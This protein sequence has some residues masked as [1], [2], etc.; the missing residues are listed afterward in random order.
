MSE[1]FGWLPVPACPSGE[2]GGA[3]RLRLADRQV[4]WQGRLDE[5]L[6]PDHIA[7]SVLMFVRRLDL[8]PLRAMIRSRGSRPGGPAT[9]P[10][11]LVALWLLAIIDGVGSAR[12]LARLC[13]EHIA[14]RWLCGGVGMNQ[15]TL[16][17]FRVDH[18][19]WLDGVFT[20]SVAALL[21]GGVISLAEVAQDGLRVRAAAGAGSL[22]RGE[23]LQEHLAAA[24]QQVE[25]LK[26]AA[27]PAAAGERGSRAARERAA[28]ERQQRLEAA[29][30]A[31]P[32]AQERLRRN[33][34]AKKKKNGK[35]AAPKQAR[36]STTD[37]EAHV[38]KMPDGGFRPA[39]NFQ[40]SAET[41]NGFI[42]G[43]DASDSGA[44]QPSLEPMVEQ[45]IE[46]TGETPEKWLVDGG[47]VKGQSITALAREHDILTYAPPMAGKG[48]RDPA[49]PAK[50]DTPE[51]AEWRARMAS[52]AAKQIYRRRAATIECVN[53]QARQRGLYRITVRSRRKARIIALWYAMAHNLI[54]GLRVARRA[55]A[56]A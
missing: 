4:V 32:E 18:E 44:D 49:E 5:L 36:V 33:G 11:I 22:R 23:S 50:G 14:Y 31:L 20:T 43:V 38:M 7:R 16:S 8:A 24:R 41:T 17:D 27:Q 26:A 48:S 12:M 25:A 6:D 19:V 2:V 13:V 30:A 56:L 9:D 34:G 46:R 35:P 3:P 40:F 29:V 53:A 47:F 1:V 37:A 28:H 10:E 42:V 52:E 21:Q 54:C 45:V 39:Y 15:H 51:Q 55:A